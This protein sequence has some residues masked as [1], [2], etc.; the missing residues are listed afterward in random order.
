MAKVSGVPVPFWSINAKSIF[1]SPFRSS[2]TS[3]FVPGI[4]NFAT[5]GL[6]FRC[7]LNLD[8]TLIFSFLLCIGSPGIGHSGQGA[9]A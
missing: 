3:Y 4:R 1:P 8:V 6:L 7:W 9:A 5:S 2:R